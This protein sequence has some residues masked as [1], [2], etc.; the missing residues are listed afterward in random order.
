M[1]L[2]GEARTFGQRGGEVDAV[3]A[4]ADHLARVT[5]LDVIAVHE[6]EARVVGDV[7][8]QR[9]VDALRHFVPAHVRHLQ[10]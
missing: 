1:E 7:V 8:P 3:V 10:V 2:H 6:V 4:A 5:G 9:V